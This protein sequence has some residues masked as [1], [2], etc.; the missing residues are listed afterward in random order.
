VRT[1]LTELTEQE[2]LERQ[3]IIESCKNTNLILGGIA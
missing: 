2:K 3:Q 1:E